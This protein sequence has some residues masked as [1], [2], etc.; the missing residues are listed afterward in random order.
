MD[1]P[2]DGILGSDFLKRAKAKVC[3]ELRTVILNEE[4][5]KMGKT[6]QSETGQPSMRGHIKL[7]RGIQ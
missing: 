7:W 4:V 3:Y 1:I 2:C 6:K 5:Y